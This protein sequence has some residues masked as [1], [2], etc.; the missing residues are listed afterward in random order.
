MILNI[1]HLLICL[2]CILFG[3]T[4]VYLLLISSK[5]VALTITTLSQLILPCCCQ[6]GVEVQVLAEP[7]RHQGGRRFGEAK[8]W[9]ALPPTNATQHSASPS[10]VT[11]RSGW[12][13]DSS[14]GSSDIMRGQ[15]FFWC[16]A[17]V[18]PVL[19]E[20]FPV[21][22]DQLFPSLLARRRGQ[23]FFLFYMCLLVVPSAR[24]L[25][26]PILDKWVGGG[27]NP[28]SLYHSSSCD[29]PGQ[30]VFLPFFIPFYVC[31]C[32]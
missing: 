21:L 15:F 9:V 19:R 14:F 8:C 11:A 28:G 12:K 13:F 27:E 17:G 18:G 22:P 24:L 16:L 4:S 10:F 6:V 20:G 2:P 32:Y 3:E 30:L 1:F 7:A 5:T 31:V 26:H 23:S 25:Q 29:I